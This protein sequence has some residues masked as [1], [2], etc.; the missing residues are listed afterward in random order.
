M[1][2]YD[3]RTHLTGQRWFCFKPIEY[4][5]QRTSSPIHHFRNAGLDLETEF[6][7]ERDKIIQHR[8]TCEAVIRAEI[9]WTV[10]GKC[11]GCW[12]YSRHSCKFS[13]IR[14]GLTSHL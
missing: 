11:Q 3:K 14:G 12:D 4:A 10:Y 13:T 7:L 6:V 2:L 9:L 1:K 8:V 5:G